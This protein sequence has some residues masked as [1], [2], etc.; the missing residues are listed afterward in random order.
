MCVYTS[1]LN[2]E[3]FQCFVS[4]NAAMYINHKHLVQKILGVVRHGVPYFTRR[5]HSPHKTQ[6]AIL[7]SSFIQQIDASHTWRSILYLLHAM[8]HWVDQSHLSL[9]QKHLGLLQTQIIAKF[10]FSLVAK[11]VA[12]TQISLQH[13]VS[14]R[15]ISS[16][17]FPCFDAV[18]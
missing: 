11:T 6:H 2:P 3:M 13:Q 16:K 7:H 14:S 5:L 15:G 1:H 8:W 17:C 9:W 4:C 12:N 18:G 10:N